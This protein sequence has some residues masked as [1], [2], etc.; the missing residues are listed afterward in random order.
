MVD[1]RLVVYTSMVLNMRMMACCVTFR[2]PMPLLKTKM[3]MKIAVAGPRWMFLVLKRASVRID[4]SK[5]RNQRKQAWPAP[6]TTVQ[7]KQMMMSF[8]F[9]DL[10]IFS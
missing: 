5:H 4:E 6:G 9:P 1:E 7:A 8:A 2:L 3:K 10:P